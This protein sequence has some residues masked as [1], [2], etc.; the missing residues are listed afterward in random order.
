MST[1]QFI[2]GFHPETPQEEAH[3]FI[4]SGSSAECCAP[5]EG[6]GGELDADGNPVFHLQQDALPE[7]AATCWTRLTGD[8]QPPQHLIG[9]IVI[10]WIDALRA[11]VIA[12]HE[13]HQTRH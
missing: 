2:V 9:A 6:L 5:L 8:R 12:T 11:H 4:A 7:M 1:P 3:F 13:R 10:G